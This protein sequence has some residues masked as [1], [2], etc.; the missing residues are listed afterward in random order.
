MSTKQR[1]VFIGAVVTGI[2]SS[3]YIAL[4]NVFCCLGVIVGAVVTAQQLAATTSGPVE[5][6]DGALLG[7]GSGALGAVISQLLDFVLN[8]LDLGS[9]AVAE[10]MLQF[11]QSLQPD[12][13]QMPMDQ[14]MQQADQGFF[15]MLVSLAFTMIIFAIFGAIGGAIGAA[16]FGSEGGDEA[17]QTGTVQ[18]PPEA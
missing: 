10:T 7:A 4:I 14:M 16:I 6:G 15:A 5:T 12:N 9:R 18:Q 11:A 8:P 3:S 17:A 2:L 13:G 1:A